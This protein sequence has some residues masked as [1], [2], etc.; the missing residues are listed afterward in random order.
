MDGGEGKGEG[1]KSAEVLSGDV[2][3]E[4][5]IL[6]L[7]RQQGDNQKVLEKIWIIELILPYP[8]IV[9]GIGYEYID[10]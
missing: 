6:F 3:R 1:E 7:K 8:D 5:C 10:I 4:L 2:S 9:R